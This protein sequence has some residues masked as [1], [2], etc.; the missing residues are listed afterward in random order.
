[1][2]AGESPDRNASPLRKKV[3]AMKTFWALLALY[4]I[5]CGIYWKLSDI[6]NELRARR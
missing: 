5:L 6:L 2:Q 4:C 1:L 3:N